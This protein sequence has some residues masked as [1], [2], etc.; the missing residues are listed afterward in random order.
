MPKHARPSRLPARLAVTTALGGVVLPLLTS[1]PAS[2]QERQEST[3]RVSGP[4]GSVPAGG[5]A[6]VTVRL[7]AGTAYVS[8]GVVD[9]QIP[10]GTGWRTV[11]RARTDSS[12]MARTAFPVTKDT[13]VRAHYRGSDVRTADTSDTV[14]VDVRQPSARTTSGN[15][16]VAEAARH[17][18]APYRYGAT[19]PNAFDCSGF[20]RY[21]YAKARGVSLPHSAAAQES[22]TRRVSK[23]AA[24][25]GDLVF[26]QGGSDHV[27]IYA[28]DGK[29]W[30]A[31]HAGGTVSL[32]SIWT[33][34]YTVG[35][36]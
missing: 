3:V 28:G 5:S 8:G 6:A 24:R 19:G 12:G 11:R 15:G 25:P 23:S 2:A 31:P 9:V 14:V 26:I 33:S 22:R 35:R 4:G 34:S 13:R 27:G 29:M 20:T 17:R 21:V 30:D 1:S 10:E 7:L 18:G 16:V 36:V 32:R